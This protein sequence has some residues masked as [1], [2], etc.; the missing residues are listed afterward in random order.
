MGKTRPSITATGSIGKSSSDSAKT[1]EA[2]GYSS[3]HMLPGI[4]AHKLEIDSLEF[5]CYDDFICGQEV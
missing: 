4:S 2:R 3:A 5:L 1:S